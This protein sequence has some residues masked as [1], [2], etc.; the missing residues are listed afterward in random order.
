MRKVNAAITFVQG[1]DS[2][3]PLSRW[4]GLSM[5]DAQALHRL[6]FR[7]AGFADWM[8]VDGPADNVAMAKASLDRPIIRALPSMN[9]LDVEDK[10]KPFVDA[11]IAEALTGDQRRLRRYL[12]NRP[13][14]LGMISAVCP[15]SS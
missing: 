4:P 9:Y 11:L 15:K 2:A 10:S 12:S 8:L 7:G 13:L 5:A 1:A 3:G 14:G 6:L